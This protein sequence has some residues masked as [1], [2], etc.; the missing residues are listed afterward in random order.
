MHPFS[1]FRISCLASLCVGVWLACAPGFGAEPAPVQAQAQLID[2][3]SF[4]CVNCFMGRSRYYYCFAVDKDILVGYQSIRVMNYNDNS[5]NF[6][7]WVDPKWQVWKA[8]PGATVPIRF[9]NQHI[10]V[11]PVNSG[12]RR[13]FWSHLKGAGIFGR[14]PEKPV[15]LTRSPASDMF[16]HNDLCRGTDTPKTR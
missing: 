6:L 13:T 3:A 1:S 16:V 14:S 9:N 5:K 8:P 4:P 12:A 7:T 2:Q 10:W 15:R 11:P